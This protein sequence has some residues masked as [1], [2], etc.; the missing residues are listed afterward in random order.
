MMRLVL[1]PNFT[2]GIK[3]KLLQTH[4]RKIGQKYFKNHEKENDT[5]NL[6]TRITYKDQLYWENQISTRCENCHNILPL[7]GAL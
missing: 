3:E 4:E 2:E 1:A 6:E 7:F 5:Y